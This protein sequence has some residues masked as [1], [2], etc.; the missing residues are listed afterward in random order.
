MFDSKK[1]P[2]EYDPKDSSEDEEEEPLLAQPTPTPP[3]QLIRTLLFRPYILNPNGPLMLF[4]LRKTVCAPQPLTPSIEAA[5]VE[6]IALPPQKKAR[7]TS[8]SL[9]DTTTEATAKPLLHLVIGLL[10]VGYTEAYGTL[11]TTLQA[12]REEITDMQFCLDQ[13]EVRKAN[14]RQYE[15]LH[16]GVTFRLGGAEREMS[17]LEFGWRVGLYSER[18]SRDVATLS[19]V[20]STETVNYTHFTHL[21]WPSIGDDGL[22]RG[23]SKTKSYRPHDQACSSVHHDDH[24]R[25]MREKMRKAMVEVEKRE[26]GGLRNNYCNMSAGDWQFSKH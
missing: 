20:R 11:H 13:S 24:H 15:P 1:G 14:L 8:P 4:T 10:F 7:F 19:G 3:T 25:K 23:T 12:A 18:E 26:S 6:S 22:M 9:Q 2:F 17:L 5:I 16:K 21:F